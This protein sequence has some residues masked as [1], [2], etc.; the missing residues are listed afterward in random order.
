MSR[1]PS[2]SKSPCRLR[3]GPPS[4]AYT[5][6]PCSVISVENARSQRHGE[7]RDV[8]FG[9][10]ERKTSTKTW[11][12]SALVVSYF[13]ATRSARPS[14]FTSPACRRGGGWERNTEGP[15]SS[16]VLEG[17]MLRPLGCQW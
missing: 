17:S 12:V 5:S 3:R 6:S 11:P 10:A 15:D 16:R 9:G 8:E 2:P 7:L 1:R 14:P 13:D 4:N